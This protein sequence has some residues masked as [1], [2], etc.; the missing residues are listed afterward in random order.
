MF[1]PI[2]TPKARLCRRIGRV[3][4]PYGQGFLGFN[5]FIAGALIYLGL[6]TNAGAAPDQL[7]ILALGDSLTAGYGLSQADS[8]PARLA[9]ALR[10]SGIAAEIVN[11]GVSGDTTSGALQRLD[12][13]MDKPY[14]LAIVELGANDALRAVDPS[15]TE[16]N[17]S[18]IVDK[19]KASGATVL[20]AGMKAPRNLGPDFARS[21]DGIFPSV[22]KRHGVAFY[23]FFLDGVAAH[24][25]LNQQDG[26]H[27]NAKG[28]TIIVERILPFVIKALGKDD[29]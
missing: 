1:V 13:L 8:F 28:V 15:V 24:P 10:D 12:W 25:D 26:M 7:R 3:F 17:L 20:L 21:F 4:R 22:T 27:P 23:P 16:E 2:Q 29:K 11:A 14:D 19:L 18:L 5:A 9:T 6:V